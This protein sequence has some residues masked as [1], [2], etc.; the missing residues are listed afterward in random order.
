MFPVI[1]QLLLKLMERLFAFSA[2]LTTQATTNTVPTVKSEIEREILEIHKIYYL[3]ISTVLSNN[4]SNV[5]RSQ[6]KKL[7]HLYN[8]LANAPHL[9]QILKT[10]MQGCC[11]Y[12]DMNVS[13][14]IGDFSDLNIRYPN[15]VTSLSKN[16]SNNGQEMNPIVLKD[17][18]NLCM[19]R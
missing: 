13:P 16:L 15:N 4:L 18:I 6:S 7:L 2:E 3:L 11:E 9:S 12:R 10:I 1:D 8:L 5:L 14:I 17:S 19:K